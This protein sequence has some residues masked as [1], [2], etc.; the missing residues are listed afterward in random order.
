MSEGHPSVGRTI[1]LL[2]EADQALAGTL[3]R[4]TQED[5][6]GASLCEGWTR[7]HVLAHLARN[8][9]AL[10]HLVLWAASG[11]ETPA[12]SSR[13]QRDQDIEDGA[14][15]PIARLRADVLSAA[16][17]F[18]ARVQSL[19][20]RTDLHPVRLGAATLPGD[21]VP[22]ARLRE[23]TFHH[24]DL[25]REFTFADVPPEVVRAGL[26][27]AAERLSRAGAPPLTLMGTDGRHWHV[28][29]GGTEVHGRPA[30]LLRWVS[31]GIDN[32]LTSRHSLPTL[33]AWG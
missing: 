1:D 14:T 12:Y 28:A 29:G 32:G 15:Q 16:D 30:D 31:R 26:V 5:L 24:V 11:Q 13:E 8:A 21:Q 17:A 20:G 23:V 33:P 10:Q 3:A 6:S 19:R 27:E 9:D 2:A 18:R 7:A 4:M 22:W 25:D